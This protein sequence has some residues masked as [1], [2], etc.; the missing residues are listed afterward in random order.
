M[1]QKL[2]IGIQGFIG[3]RN[4]EYLYV[5]KTEYI[6]R[7]KQ[8]GKQFFLSRPRRFGKSLLISAMKAYWEGRKDLFNGLKIA[9]L[10]SSNHDTWK[11]YPV[12]CF[13]FNGQNYK[14]EGALESILDEYLRRWETEYSISA[15]NASIGE[16]FR[17]LLIKAKD[18]TGL[19]C[20]VLVDEYDKPL[21]DVVDNKSLQE[22]NKDV[23]KGFFSTLK[24][25]D[26][27]IRFVFITGVTKFHKVSIFSDLNQLN[28]ISMNED[29]A[30]I[31]GITDKE[32]REYFA[33]EIKHL[34][35]KQNISEDDCLKTLK[36][37]YDGYCF[38]PSGVKVYNPYSLLKSF[39]EK[40]FGNYWFETGTPTFL[41]KKLKHIDFDIRKLGDN[42]LY[43]S[44]GMLN[45]Y[46]GD[47]PS[48]IPLL[49]QTGY[50]TIVGYDRVSREFTL[51]YPNNEVKY[52]FLESMMPEYVSDCGAGSGKDIFSIRRYVENGDLEA[53]KNAFVALFAS[54]PYA[55]EDDLLEHYF[56]TVIYLVFT[57]LGKFAVCELHTFNGRIDC[58][59]ETS[60]FIYIF[61]F[62]RN[63][64][65]DEA[66]KQIEDKGYALPYA[67]DPRKLF[68]I[69]VSFSSKDRLLT[70]WKT[71]E[72]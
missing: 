71:S 67:A 54:I 3:L 38:N 59:V 39:F 45:D 12:F 32:L 15:S 60:R 68:K 23:F 42:T 48:P 55:N 28:D 6:Y 44:E 31:C 10:E 33:D 46:I 11:K 9:E 61:E 19:R 17:N 2:P 56:Q 64:S 8:S 20:V 52:G 49:Y 5:D 40:D 25:Y 1:A 13:D 62:K 51:A 34:G 35:E 57:L 66:L 16:R 65:A 36:E 4:D 26:E 22:H 47:E 30:G 14:T 18:N 7:L 72:N 29:F 70:E 24:S 58:K 27:Y 43:A 37:Q 53:L 41:V 69:G 21:L 63:V 50:L